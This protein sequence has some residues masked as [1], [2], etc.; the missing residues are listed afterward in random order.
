MFGLLAPILLLTLLAS[1]VHGGNS[2]ALTGQAGRENPGPPL[3]YIVQFDGPMEQAWKDQ[4]AERG[5]EFLGYIPYF[6]FK[7]RMNPAQARQPENQNPIRPGR[8][9]RCAVALLSLPCV[10]SP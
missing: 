7:V 2:A 3:Y 9:S 6:A 10:S 4:A 5:A 8:S 1:P